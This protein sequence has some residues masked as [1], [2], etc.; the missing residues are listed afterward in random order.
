MNGIMR[1]DL[2][3]VYHNPPKKF[4]VLGLCLEIS[5]IRIHLYKP[6]YLD[7]YLYKYHKSDLFNL[8]DIFIT[9]TK[10]QKVR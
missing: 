5:F 6:I 1:R 10:F 2:S 4:H 8:S 9:F 3:L 7:A